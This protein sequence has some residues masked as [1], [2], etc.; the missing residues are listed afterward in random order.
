LDLVPGGVKLTGFYA[1][2]MSCTATRAGLISGRYRRIGLFR[3]SKAS[4][5][6]LITQVPFELTTQELSAKARGTLERLGYSE[7]RQDRSSGLDYAFD[8]L[9]YT[10]RREHRAL[11]RHFHSGNISPIKFWH[12][13]SPEWMYPLDPTRAR[14]AP[15][16]R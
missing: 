2:A 13:E 1:N 7:R 4:L 15:I 14:V 10:R 3:R 8:M 12:R 9:L 5:S 16:R 6:L 11:Q